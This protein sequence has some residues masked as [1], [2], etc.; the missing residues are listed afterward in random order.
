[1]GGYYFEVGYYFEIRVLAFMSQFKR[2][3]A[4]IYD[5][6]LIWVLPPLSYFR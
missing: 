3:V 6:A 5:K 2:Y 4:V 1:M